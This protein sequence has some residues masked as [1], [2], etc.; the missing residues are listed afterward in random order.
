MIKR[1]SDAGFNSL[2]LD[3]ITK[4]GLGVD[5]VMEEEID[6]DGSVRLQSFIQFL[7]TQEHGF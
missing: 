1:S 7:Y 5:L 4:T 2:I 3:Q 6:P